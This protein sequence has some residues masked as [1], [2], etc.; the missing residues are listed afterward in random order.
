MTTAKQKRQQ[1]HNARFFFLIHAVTWHMLIRLVFEMSG[2]I[3]HS[4]SIFNLREPP[5]HVILRYTAKHSSIDI[6]RMI[7]ITY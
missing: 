3:N 2:L 7:I 4:Q 5:P 1:K 6:N